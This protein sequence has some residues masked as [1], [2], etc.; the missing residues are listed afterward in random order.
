MIR[1]TVGAGLLVA[2]AVLGVAGSFQPVVSLIAPPMG[3]EAETT[4]SLT[5]WGYQAATQNASSSDVPLPTG[6]V[7]GYGLLAAATLL[8]LGA[9]LVSRGGRVGAIGR[10]VAMAAAGAQAAT[11][12]AVWATADG[13]FQGAIVSDTGYR[14]SIG[15]AV[16][17]LA[18]A[19][20]LAITGAVLA[21]QRVDPADAA[22]RPRLTGTA[23]YRVDGEDDDATP[24][25]GIPLGEPD[26][27][28]GGS[29][30]VGSATAA[31]PAST[32]DQ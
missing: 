2:A 18:L 25:F 30:A 27:S 24:P 21:Q 28:T 16:W 19:A 11:A 22:A 6:P 3:A 31:P 5:G 23:V 13:T 10:L 15:D 14:R 4:L 32:V 7:H 1:R 12:W 29:T 9:I 26:H 17:L 8:V 20:V